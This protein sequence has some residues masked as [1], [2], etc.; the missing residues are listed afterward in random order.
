VLAVILL[1]AA[2]VGPIMSNVEQ[3]TYQL[4]ASDGSIEIRDYDPRLVATVAVSG[5]RKDAIR[6]GFKI[7][8]DYI[9][10]NNTSESN[11]SMTAPVEQSQGEKIAMTA[12]VEQQTDGKDWRITFS[13]P[14]EY[15]IETLPRPTSKSIQI[16]L[17]P[18]KTQAA[19]TFS[20]MNSS[21]NL[22]KHELA[23]KNY[24]DQSE[25]VITG[26]PYYAFYNPP[27]TLPFLRRNEVLFD[28]RRK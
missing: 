17:I 19:I 20:G 27:W 18:A 24:I 10:G 26:S 21:E 7:L 9:F 6:S 22:E 5:P 11:I 14:S 4:I 1:A 12:P 3:P 13:M 16:E 8:A 25:W 28:I 23:L 15:S 2:L